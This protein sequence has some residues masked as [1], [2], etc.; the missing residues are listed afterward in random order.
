MRESRDQVV[1]ASVTIS[2][3]RLNVATFTFSC[4]LAFDLCDD[5]KSPVATGDLRNEYRQCISIHL[6]GWA[7]PGLVLGIIDPYKTRH[8]ASLPFRL[9]R[10]EIEQQHGPLQMRDPNAFPQERDARECASYTAC[11]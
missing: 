3:A 5:S 1:V 2:Q 10:W 8:S 7:S 9:R 6:D 11:V 4:P